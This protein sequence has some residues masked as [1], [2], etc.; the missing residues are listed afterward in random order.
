MFGVEAS[1]LLQDKNLIDFIISNVWTTK[2]KMGYSFIF[3]FTKRT[4]W[5]IW[6]HKEK[7]FFHLEKLNCSKLCTKNISYNYCWKQ[8]E[9]SCRFTSNLKSDQGFFCKV[10]ICSVVVISFQYSSF[11]FA[12]STVRTLKFRIK[13]GSAVVWN[14]IPNDT[15]SVTPFL[16]TSCIKKIIL[17]NEDFL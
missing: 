16:S 13:W 1:N 11:E 8:S 9:V 6:F 7:K 10:G 4:H 2:M 17:T 12:F 3:V 15:I 14:K 5:K